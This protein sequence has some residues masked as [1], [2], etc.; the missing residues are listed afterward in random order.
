MTELVGRY[1]GETVELYG[2]VS[3]LLLM[4]QWLLTDGAQWMVRLVHKSSEPEKVVADI[5]IVV[6]AYGVNEGIK[7][8]SHAA[9][10]SDVLVTGVLGFD[11]DAKV[12][13]DV[14]IESFDNLSILCLSKVAALVNEP[15]SKIKE[16]SQ[17]PIVGGDL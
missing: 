5:T 16:L 17:H 15:L 13:L 10:T 9:K 11:E 14:V 2:L 3:E 8:G 6:N 1:E 12:A 4:K 7:Q